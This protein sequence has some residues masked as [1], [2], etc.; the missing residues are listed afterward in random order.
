MGHLIPAGTGFSA[1]RKIEMIKNVEVKEASK[2]S[3]KKDKVSDKEDSGE[4]VKI[5]K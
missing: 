4:S 2:E 5:Q 3:E 1:H